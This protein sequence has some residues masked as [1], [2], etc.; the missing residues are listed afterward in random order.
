MTGKIKITNGIDSF[1]INKED[2]STFENNG[3]LT[4]AEFK[5]Q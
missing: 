5:K 4:I 3:Y 1:F 2:L